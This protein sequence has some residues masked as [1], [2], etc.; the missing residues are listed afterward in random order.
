MPITGSGS[1]VCDAS[2]VPV[3]VRHLK[4]RP[5]CVSSYPAPGVAPMIEQLTG[6]ETVARIFRFSG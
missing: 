3:Q 1:L 4:N 2:A 5:Q 6:S